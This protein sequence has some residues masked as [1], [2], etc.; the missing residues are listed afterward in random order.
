MMRVRTPQA[1]SAIVAALCIVLLPSAALPQAGPQD[2][3]ALFSTAVAPNVLLVVDNSGSMNH[4]VWH[5]D[6]DPTFDYTQGTDGCDYWTNTRTYNV[7]V[8]SGDSSPSGATDTTFR[9]GTFDRCGNERE[10]FVDPTVQ[11]KGDST[12]WQGAYLNWYFSDYIDDDT[13]DEVAALANGQTSACLISEGHAATFDKY[14]RSRIEAAR[15]ILHD[16]VCRVNAAGE[17]RFGMALFRASSDPKG[18]YVKVEIDDYSPQH[19]NDLLAVEIELIEGEAWT[20]LAETLYEVYSYFQSRGSNRVLGKD[21]S[22]KFDV[23]DED[24]DGDTTSS[25][26]YLADPM[27]DPDSGEFLPCRKN[28]VI[29]ITDGEPTRDDFD[30]MDYDRFNDKLI[31]DYN[32]DSADPFPENF[33]G[34]HAEW[35]GGTGGHDDDIFS[36]VETALYLDDVAHFM[37]TNDARPDLDGDQFIDVYTVGFTTSPYADAL[38]K[39]TAESSNGLFFRSNNAE[40]LTVALT[41]SL[42]DIVAKSQVFTA[43]TIPA[44]RTSAANS[45]FASY[46]VPLRE[47]FW[48][49]HLKQFDFTVDGEVRDASDPS[50]C[51]L[52]DPDAASGSCQ[53]GPL[54]LDSAAFWDAADEIPAAGA[55]KLFT[56]LDADTRAPGAT[57]LRAQ[58]FDEDAFDLDDLG[59]DIGG[60]GDEDDGNDDDESDD[61]DDEE[62][63]IEMYDDVDYGTDDIDDEEDLV[64]ALVEYARGCEFGSDPCDERGTPLAPRKLADIF[65]SNPIVIGAPNATINHSTYQ[66]FAATYQNRDKVIYA[67]SNGGFMHGF[68]AG[69]WQPS[70]AGPPFVPAGHDRG[71]GEELMGFASYAARDNMA[72]LPLQENGKVYYMDGSPQAADVWL[73]PNPTALPSASSEWATVL[74]G[75]MRQGGR[76]VF[77]LDVTNPSEEIGSRAYPGYLWEFPCEDSSCDAEREWMGETWSAPVFTR[78]RVAVNGDLG[79]TGEGYERWVVIF[80]A[81]YDVC[82][83]PHS[84]EYNDL[85]ECPLGDKASRALYMVDVTTGKVLAAKRFQLTGIGPESEMKFSFTSAPAVF[86]LDFDGFADVVVIGDL[87]GNLWKWV[88]DD[89]I[90][91]PIHGAGTTDPYEWEFVRLL[92]TVKCESP[93]CPEE[94]RKSFFFPPTGAEL[95]GSLIL[96]FGSGERNQLQYLGEAGTNLENNRYYVMRDRDPLEQTGITVT[97]SDARYHDV[98]PGLRRRPDPVADE[99]RV[100]GGPGGRLLP[101]G[102]GRR[103]VRHQ[104]GD[105]PG[106]GADGILPADDP[107]D[108]VRDGRSRLP[109]RVQHPVR[110]P[111]TA[112]PERGQRRSAGHQGPDR[113]RS[114]DQD[115]GVDRSD[116]GPG[117]GRRLPEQGPGPVE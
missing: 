1:I 103:E 26:N 64:E 30:G 35:S 8:N 51:A 54:L 21:G 62:E 98:T 100:P 13:A 11:A 23:Y 32:D 114:A 10:I 75:G 59:I 29:V 94:R 110:R 63:A 107:H 70:Q 39:K 45:L 47:S 46:F 104:L 60:D 84:L 65:H 81:G 68:H 24:T 90:E 56:S 40:E 43:A 55:R 96:A 57:V 37:A 34:V 66:Q 50:N 85:A 78:V 108:A 92:E 80:G 86:D 82:G 99:L 38:L 18:G 7:N 22:T 117:R 83:D 44:S 52:D 41:E 15:N 74:A 19:G 95:H 36:N 115:Q 5:P 69:E 9:N 27:F 89:V 17:V 79:P 48:E 102:R 105:L 106:D 76:V 112:E 53:K 61:V 88:I 97:G 87:G 113:H 101:G 33:N 111:R 20:P 16:V 28:F 91:D 25:S 12:R 2:D 67:G 4:V 116:D 109:L 93:T 31:G 72:Q 42:V 3:T 14:R 77:A 73:Y 58:D 71:T 49:G 6:F